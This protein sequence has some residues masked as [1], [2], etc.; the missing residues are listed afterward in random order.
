MGRAV[1]TCGIGQFIFRS[2]YPVLEA[3]CIATSLLYAD[4]HLFLISAGRHLGDSVGELPASQNDV[5]V[6]EGRG[7]DD[8]EVEQSQENELCSSRGRDADCN[9]P[10][11]EAG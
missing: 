9:G 5:V 10:L 8:E 2:L 6:D 4:L 7:E 1:R 11:L 3:F